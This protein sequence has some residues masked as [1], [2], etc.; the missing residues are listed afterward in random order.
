M[1]VHLSNPAAASTHALY[2]VN[3]ITVLNGRITLVWASTPDNPDCPDDFPTFKP[4]PIGGGSYAAQVKAAY[5][6]TEISH[7]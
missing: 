3:T 4:L 1:T 6:V 7:Y 5:N 2:G